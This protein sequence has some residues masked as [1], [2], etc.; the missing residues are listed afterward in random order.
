MKNFPPGTRAIPAGHAGAA[1]A[2]SIAGGACAAAGSPVAAPVAA[3]GAKRAAAM[4]RT[5]GDMATKVMSA[6][7]AA[8]AAMPTLRR[9]T[10]GLPGGTE[11]AMVGSVVRSSTTSLASIA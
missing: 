7:A 4:R 8:P 3:A 5:R 2:G 10:R 1:F 9:P 6:S 11:A